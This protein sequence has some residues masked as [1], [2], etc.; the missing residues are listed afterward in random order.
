MAGDVVVTMTRRDI[1]S[2]PQWQGGVPQLCVNDGG[3]KYPN[4][5]K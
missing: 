3:R 5:S 2:G 4:K 1:L